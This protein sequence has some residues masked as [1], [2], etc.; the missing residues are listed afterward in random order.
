MELVCAVTLAFVSLCSSTTGPPSA[1]ST[2]QIVRVSPSTDLLGR[3]IAVA[4]PTQGGSPWG[5]PRR[6]AFCAPGGI[7]R[8]LDGGQTWSLVPTDHVAV[9]AAGT[10]MPLAPRPPAAPVCQSVVF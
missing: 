9:L 10:E 4:P 5:D 1:G 8:T 6:L 3:Q 7:K 2:L